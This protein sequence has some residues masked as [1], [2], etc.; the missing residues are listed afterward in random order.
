M[1]I[2]A[3][4]AFAAYVATIPGAN[5]MIS[6]VGECSP[7]GVCV[8][9]VGFGLYAPS[10]V[11]LVGAALVLRDFIHEE[12]GIAAAFAAIVVGSFA[13]ILFAAPQLALAAFLAFTLAELADLLVYAP[14]RRRRL[15]LAVLL[16]GI[17]GAFV[18]SVVFLYVAFGGVDYLAGLIV[19]KMW[20]TIAAVPFLLAFKPKPKVPYRGGKF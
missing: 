2:A 4:M 1:W 20:A 14:L 12:F 3:L 8:L 17:A 16:S 18:D 10:G 5:Y 19:G 6:H 7:A 9:P 13:S 11:L 15:W